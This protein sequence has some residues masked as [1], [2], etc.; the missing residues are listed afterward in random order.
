MSRAEMSEYASSA[1]ASFFSPFVARRRRTAQRNAHR[2]AKALA[3]TGAAVGTIA[4]RTGLP[5]DVIAMLIAGCTLPAAAPRKNVPAPV[6]TTA[7]SA[8]VQNSRNTR[9][10]GLPTS[11]IANRLNSNNLQISNRGTGVALA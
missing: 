2:T 7:A 6:P 1:V 9:N 3:A 8:A 10:T 4:Q 5:R 11:Q